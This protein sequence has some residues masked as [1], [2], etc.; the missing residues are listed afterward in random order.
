MVD[1]AG[2]LCVD[3]GKALSKNKSAMRCRGCVNRQR[4]SSKPLPVMIVDAEYHAEVINHRWHKHPNGYV[5]GRPF[6]KEKWLL[7]TFVWFL[8]TGERRENL[9]HVNRIK[10]DC[11]LEN[12]RPATHALQTHNRGKVQSKHGLPTGVVHGTTL[13]SPFQ[14]YVTRRGFRKYL[15]SFKT[16]ESAHKAYDNARQV[17][18]EFESLLAS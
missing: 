6:G 5:C 15:G 10:H 2:H 18:E 17:I 12:L 3:C 13:A 16:A 7:H 4:A 14:A 11:R 1:R 8:A 9:D